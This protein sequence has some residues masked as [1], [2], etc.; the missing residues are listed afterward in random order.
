MQKNVKFKQ[1]IKYFS[2]YYTF[3]LIGA[4]LTLILNILVALR[5]PAAGK[6]A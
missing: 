6:L 2:Y 4:S 3:C 5:S 1:L